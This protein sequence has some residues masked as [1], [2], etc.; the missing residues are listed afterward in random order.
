VLHELL[1]EHALVD[2]V[3]LVQAL[4][5]PRDRYAQSIEEALHIRADRDRG[6]APLR[7]LL[8]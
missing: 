2:L 6:T 7:H 4:G 5:I 3:E 8:R 1:L